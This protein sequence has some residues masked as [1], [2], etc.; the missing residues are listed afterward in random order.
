MT[1]TGGYAF[2]VAHLFERQKMIIETKEGNRTK[3]K[4]VPD[5]YEE[6]KGFNQK[7][8]TTSER[9]SIGYSDIDSDKWNKIFASPKGK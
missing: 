5:D 7:D 8:L 9:K 1:K 2:L 3:I 4:I 6:E